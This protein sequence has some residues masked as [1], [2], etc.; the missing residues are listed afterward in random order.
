MVELK[1]VKLVQAMGGLFTIV[2]CLEIFWTMISNIQM[3]VYINCQ[4]A[5]L[6]TRRNS[7]IEVIKVIQSYLIVM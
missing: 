4:L 7:Y 5:N 6:H 2:K 1:T 3:T